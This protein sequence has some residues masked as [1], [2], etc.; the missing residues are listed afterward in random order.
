[1][2]ANAVRLQL[3]A[4]AY[5]LSNFLRTLAMPDEME[6]WSL[7][8]ICEKVVKIGAKVVAYARY[9][10][11]QMAEVAVPC[12]L[13]RR[14]CDMIDDLRPREPAPCRRTGRVARGKRRAKCAR[15]AAKQ[16]RIAPLRQV[17]AVGLAILLSC[18][19]SP[20]HSAF[21]LGRDWAIQASIRGGWAAYLGN[22]RLICNTTSS[23]HLVSGWTTT[24]L[25]GHPL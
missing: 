1:M 24:R 17:M 21:R 6:S 12:D 4:L 5:N 8:T 7:T 3:H 22:V 13:F 10:V 16:A 23:C 11:F 25:F 2:K 20:I 18:R 9:A 19:L 15:V 14:I